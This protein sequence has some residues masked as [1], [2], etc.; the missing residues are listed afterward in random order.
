[1]LYP[2]SIRFETKFRQID[3]YLLTRNLKNRIYLKKENTTSHLYIYKNLFKF[4]KFILWEKKWPFALKA[5]VL[6][7]HAFYVYI[8]KCFSKKPNFTFI[9]WNERR[10]FEFGWVLATDI[11]VA[12]KNCQ[13]TFSSIELN[14]FCSKIKFSRP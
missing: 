6:F 3:V 8:F 5:A 11:M 12:K 9:Y 2:I 10:H 14:I 4:I 7:L 13:I 1:M